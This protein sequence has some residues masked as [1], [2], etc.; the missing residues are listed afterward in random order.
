M[1]SSAD[2]S[3]RFVFFRRFM[4]SVSVISVISNLFKVSPDLRLDENH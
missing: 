4:V 2:M 1:V 3:N